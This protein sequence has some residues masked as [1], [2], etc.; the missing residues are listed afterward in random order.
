M[1]RKG[2]LWTV[3]WQATCV[4]SGHV[5]RVKHCS[6]SLVVVYRVSTGVRP[7]IGFFLF[8]FLFLVVVIRLWL[9]DRLRWNHVAR[10]W[11][12]RKHLHEIYTR[13][14]QAAALG[15]WLCSGSS[16]R[17]ARQSPNCFSTD[18]LIRCW[19]W[20]ADTICRHR[21]LIFHLHCELKKTPKYLSYLLQN[22][23]DSDKIWYC[24]E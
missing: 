13:P 10:I 14:K 9:G 1:S 6:D 21:H 22:P 5:W 23:T 17:F 16:T 20:M 15:N 3:G 8:L 7:L 18:N 11:S 12:L 2:W 24:P 4:I 19:A